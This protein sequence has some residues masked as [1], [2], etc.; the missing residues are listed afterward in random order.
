MQYTDTYL[1]L[2]GVEGCVS[3]LYVLQLPR[4]TACVQYRSS[5]VVR[6]VQTNAVV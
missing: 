1:G 6:V 4:H 5:G 2:C 3:G